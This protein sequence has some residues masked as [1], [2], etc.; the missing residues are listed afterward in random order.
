MDLLRDREEAPP[1]PLAIDFAHT[2]RGTGLPTAPPICGHSALSNSQQAFPPMWHSHRR[3]IL[4]RFGL[5]PMIR[6]S[7]DYRRRPRITLLF[8]PS[9][10]HSCFASRGT[11]SLRVLQLSP[12]AHN[13]MTLYPIEYDPY[14]LENRYNGYNTQSVDPDPDES[15][16]RWPKTTSTK[17]PPH[18]CPKASLTA[19]FF[20]CSPISKT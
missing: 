17:P 14:N 6:T 20:G 16:L 19:P 15:R 1:R 11:R 13:L 9:V 5:T 18:T 4:A 10:N 12:G 7:G 3:Y 2:H 8:T